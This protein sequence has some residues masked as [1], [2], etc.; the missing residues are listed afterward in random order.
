[1]ILHNDN[2]KLK[3][4]FQSCLKM[5]LHNDSVQ[6]KLN[7]QSYWKMILHNDNVKW[8]LNFQS[9]MTSLLKLFQ[10]HDDVPVSSHARW[11]Y[12]VNLSIYIQI[13]ILSSL[14]I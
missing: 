11:T 12:L 5:I 1:M 3:L 8:K 6:W 14:L 9:S 7:F 4:N 10:M 2:V 13:C